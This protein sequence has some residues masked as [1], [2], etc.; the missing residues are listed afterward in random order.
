MRDVVRS[1]HEALPNTPRGQAAAALARP[2]PTDDFVQWCLRTFLR[3]VGDIG[4]VV[5]DPLDLA[6]MA[7]ET[8]RHIAAD[9]ARVIGAVNEAGDAM[10]RVGLPVLL[11]PPEG[12]IPLFVRDQPG[13]PRVRP[14]S[15]D[16]VTSAITEDGARLSS[17]VIMPCVRAERDRAHRRLRRRAE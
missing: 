17:D 11:N 1:L 16:D 14:T 13:A 2:E 6:P 4:A 10:R 7:I 12:S 3:I 8:Q 5:L 9:A 15:Q